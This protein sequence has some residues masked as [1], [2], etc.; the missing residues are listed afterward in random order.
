MWRSYKSN[1]F[2]KGT[3]L[4]FTLKCID[5]HAYTWNSQPVIKRTAAG[6][7][8]TSPAI[9]VSGATYTKIATLAEILGLF[10]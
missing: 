6:N 8:L 2:T 10:F 5:G 7:L 9:L 4:L 1:I 3:L